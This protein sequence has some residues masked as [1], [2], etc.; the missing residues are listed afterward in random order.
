ME[1]FIKNIFDIDEEAE[2]YQNSLEKEK[3]KLMQDRKSKIEELDKEYINVL[4]D[5]KSNLNSRLKNIEA[6]DIK[7]L[8]DYKKK[9]EE[10][11]NIFAQKKVLLVRSFAKSILE[12]GELSGQ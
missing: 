6:Q 7:Q 12:S 8:D 3:L 2:K 4:A 10:I 9:T 11:K 1:N 5:E